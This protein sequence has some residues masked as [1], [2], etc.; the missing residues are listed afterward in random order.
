MAPTART[1]GF[2]TGIGRSSEGGVDVTL[3]GQQII[4]RVSRQTY[5]FAQQRTSARFFRL[6]C[7]SET[8]FTT[9]A[10]VGL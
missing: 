6:T 4:L 3:D 1:T 5:F 2:S 10:T 8:V 7:T 9:I